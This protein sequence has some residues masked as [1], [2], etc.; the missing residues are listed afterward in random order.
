MKKIILHLTNW[1]AYYS[2]CG[3]SGR[4]WG[5]LF[6]FLFKGFLKDEAFAEAHPKRYLLGV[7]G[8]MLLAVC[9]G[10]MLIWWPLSLLMKVVDKKIDELP[11]E[12]DE[13][14]I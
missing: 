2:L 6:G 14:E 11:D 13:F 1:V 5:N 4:A 12:K 7:I 8:I 10:L 3:I 9:S